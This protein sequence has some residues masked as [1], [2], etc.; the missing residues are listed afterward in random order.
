MKIRVKRISAV[1]V[2][3]L[4]VM[5]IWGVNL[6]VVKVSLREMDSLAFNSIRFSLA[7]MILLILA[8]ST[9]V[10]RLDRRTAA[11]LF[12]IGL[13]GNGLYQVL[14]ILGIS[15]TMAGVTSLILASTPIFVSILN[16]LIGVERI[17]IR[18]WGGVGSSFL[19]I[20]LMINPGSLAEPVG[21]IFILG[22]LLILAAT[23]CWAVYTVLSRPLLSSLSPLQFVAYTVALGTPF[24]VL[25]S[26]PSLMRQNFAAVSWL[27]WAG[28]VFSSTLAIGFAY[29]VWYSG[30][31]EIGST[32][33]AIYENLSPVVAVLFARQVLGESLLPTQLLG[34]VL[35]FLGIYLTRFSSQQS[36]NRLS[37]E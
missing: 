13:I 15:M 31:R 35:V 12:V 29:V 7:G 14:F 22:D 18:V 30:V 33:T 23:V 9:G 20:L 25:V 4:V 37:S 27:G 1:D 3:L 11:R 8:F 19:G 17:G 5:V 26:I 34:A 6:T 24:L 10:T 21:L 32:R 36:S 28:L 16:A 2:L